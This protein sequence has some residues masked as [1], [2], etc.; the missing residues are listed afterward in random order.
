MPLKSNGKTSNDLR[1]PFVASFLWAAV[2]HV[3]SAK[4]ASI[5]H[6]AFMVDSRVIE[7]FVFRI[8]RY[9]RLLD[10]ALFCHIL[11]LHVDRLD[12]HGRTK[13][14]IMMAN[15][16]CRPGFID[17]AKGSVYHRPNDNSECVYLRVPGRL[18]VFVNDYSGEYRWRSKV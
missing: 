14:T 5:C 11:N 8:Q 2:S 1:D 6:K 4:K 10:L 17:T 13:M 3:R 7:V 15:G 18:V 16:V 12:G 9:S